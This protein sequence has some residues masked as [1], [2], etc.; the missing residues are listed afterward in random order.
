[1]SGRLCI[2]VLLICV[3]APLG[4]APITF[5]TA[6]PVSQGEFIVRQQ[7]IVRE[8]SQDEN[9]S[10]NF[11]TKKQDTSLVSTIVYGV[12]PELTLFASLP[13]V[14]RELRDANQGV[15]E[16]KGYGDS[17]LTARYT[18]YKDDF[19]GGSFRIAPFIGVRLS[20]GR[21]D[22]EDKFGLLPMSIQSGMG[23]NAE[24]AGIVATYAN[25]EWELD[26]QL[27]YVNNHTANNVDFGNH[28]KVDI[29]FQYRLFPKE[30]SQNQD[31]FI[32]GVIE[33]NGTDKDKNTL[34]GFADQNSGGV[35]Y[36]LSPGIQYVSERY[37]LEAVVQLPIKHPTGDARLELD[38][39][40]R[41]GF[42][43]N[44]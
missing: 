12:T 29:S 6:L 28:L 2:A 5:N 43:I 39:I 22:K 8:A 34:A 16:T 31:Y 37:I 36:S 3:S 7:F 10:N 20:T 44:F 38:Q 17:Q 42:R 14:Y 40:F 9:N 11:A 41:M 4:S 32:N 25:Y 27:S 21:T 24:F 13:F 35:S 19:Q 33:L 1:M 23:A 18:I 26:G 15:R 30:L